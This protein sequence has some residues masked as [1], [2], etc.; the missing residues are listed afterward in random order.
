MDADD[1]FIPTIDLFL[2]GAFVKRERLNL[3]YRK[4]EDFVAIM[5]VRTGYDMS[6]DTLYRIEKGS[7]VPDINFIAAFNIMLGRKPT[8][9]TIV[10]S[11]VP[12][13]WKDLG[14]KGTPAKYEWCQY[15]LPSK[16]TFSPDTPPF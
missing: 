2:F 16:N 6:K 4:A 5:K 10:E 3:G 12:Q 11:C 15:E 13:E 8:D 7:R 14:D 9:M 1:E